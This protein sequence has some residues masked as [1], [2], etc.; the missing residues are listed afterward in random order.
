MRKV[1]LVQL[2]DF[3]W[4]QIRLAALGYRSAYSFEV[5]CSLPRSTPDKETVAIE[6]RL[7]DV[8][9]QYCGVASARSCSGVV[10]GRPKNSR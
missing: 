3:M 9:T 10:L 7:R 1:F 2:A 6:R 4:R 8:L 5:A